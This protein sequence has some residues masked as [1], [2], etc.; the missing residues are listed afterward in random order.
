[1]QVIPNTEP[2]ELRAGDTWKWTRSIGEYP[3]PAWVLKYRFKN[4]SSSFE[5]VGTQS[6]SGHMMTV[7][8]STSAGIRAGRYAYQAFAENNT[9]AERFTVG[10]GYLSVLADFG[11]EGLVDARSHAR[12]ALE[13][14][15]AVLEKRATIDQEEY[16]IGGRSLKRTPIPDLLR[17]RQ[18][19]RNEVRD[20]DAADRIRKGLDS[21]RRILVRFR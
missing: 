16:T 3:A 4:D 11:N 15:E 20:E 10:T 1:M 21:G 8:R 13:A 17:L 9:T 2:A 6:G 12:R 14:I 18:L 7:A 5:V 19:Y